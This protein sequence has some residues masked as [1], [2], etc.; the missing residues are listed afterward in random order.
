MSVANGTVLFSLLAEARR[1]YYDHQPIESF[2]AA[3]EEHG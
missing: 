1:A 2:R 3:D